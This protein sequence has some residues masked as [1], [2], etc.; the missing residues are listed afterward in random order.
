MDILEIVHPPANVIVTQFGEDI[1]SIRFQLFFLSAGCHCTGA[2][3][4][5][6]LCG[7]FRTFVIRLFLVGS[8]AILPKIIREVA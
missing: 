1:L 7:Q 8:F 3:G 5:H 4:K 2:I 6:S